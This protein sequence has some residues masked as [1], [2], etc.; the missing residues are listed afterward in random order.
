MIPY[1]SIVWGPRSNK[2]VLVCFY[3]SDFCFLP[4][5][6]H[7]EDFTTKTDPHKSPPGFAVI[8]VHATCMFQ[9]KHIWWRKFCCNLFSF[10][11]WK[12]SNFLSYFWQGKLKYHEQV[13][14]GFENMPMAFIGMLKGENIGKAIVK[15]W[16][17]D[18]PGRLTQEN[19]ILLNA[20]NS[21][22]KSYD[23]YVSVILLDVW[24]W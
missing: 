2:S 12:C 11:G 19:V 6:P 16:R 18:I 8:L 14:E 3:S 10:G 24:W 17:S 23:Q 5:W 20:F 13:T 1:V 9:M 22:V 7:V 21:L 15:V 4:L